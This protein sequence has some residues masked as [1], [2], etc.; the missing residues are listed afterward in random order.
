M[1]VLRRQHIKTTSHADKACAQNAD[2]QLHM[3]P[4]L[5]LPTLTEPKDQDRT[6]ELAL[7]HFQKSRV[8]CLGRS[9]VETPLHKWSSS[10]VS[11]L[12]LAP[13][14]LPPVSP[15]PLKTQPSPVGKADLRHHYI[16]HLLSRHLLDQ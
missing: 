10:K 13:P 6:L 15:S 16:Y 5:S 9:G 14:A 12:K 11:R 1:I 2:L 4:K 7:E 3:E 8:H